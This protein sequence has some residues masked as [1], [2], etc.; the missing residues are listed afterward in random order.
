MSQEGLDNF[1]KNAVLTMIP[2]SGIYLRAITCPITE[3]YFYTF[4]N[5]TV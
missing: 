5:N 4:N 1:E 3:S 2:A